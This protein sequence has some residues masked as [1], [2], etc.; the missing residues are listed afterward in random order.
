MNKA[1][2]EYYNNNNNSDDNLKM[3]TK[4]IGIITTKARITITLIKTTILYITH[5]NNNKK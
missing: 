1:K 5:S 2:V 3:M 4:K